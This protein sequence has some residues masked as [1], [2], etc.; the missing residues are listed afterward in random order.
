MIVQDKHNYLNGTEIDNV[1]FLNVVTPIVHM[2]A[3]FRRLC[4][5]ITLRSSLYLVFQNSK[6]MYFMC[7][8]G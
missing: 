6:N 7:Y 1:L 8:S 2:Y 4:A 5:V 3:E